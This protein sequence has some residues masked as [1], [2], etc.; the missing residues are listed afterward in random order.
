MSGMN[1]V[2]LIED[3]CGTQSGQPMYVVRIEQC[4]V[5][6]EPKEGDEATK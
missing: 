4:G 2:R 5:L 3:R 6:E 1:V